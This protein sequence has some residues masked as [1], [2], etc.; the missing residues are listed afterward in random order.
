MVLH[1]RIVG[2]PRKG[3]LRGWTAPKDII[4][5]ILRGRTDPHA[6]GTNRVFEYFGEGAASISATGKST[7]C[8]MGAE[9]GATTSLFPYDQSMKRYL[10]SCGRQETADLAERFAGLLQADPEVL[11]APTRYFTE[12]IEIDLD[13]LE[14]HIVGPHSPDKASTISGMPAHISRGS[15]L[16]KR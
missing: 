7:I 5:R 4:L 1:P 9:L 2:F 8:N 10:E 6:G 16:K 13:K 15:L 3:R 11:A 12:L 14:P